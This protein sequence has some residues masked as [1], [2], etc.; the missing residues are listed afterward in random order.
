MSV[1]TEAFMLIVAAVL[2]AT[3]WHWL[4]RIEQ[5]NSKIYHDGDKKTERKEDLEVRKKQ[6]MDELEKVFRGEKSRLDPEAL[7]AW[8]EIS[9]REGER[10]K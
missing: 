10:R 6:L 3:L 4:R 7:E 5:K 1:Q 2:L 8:K 9:A